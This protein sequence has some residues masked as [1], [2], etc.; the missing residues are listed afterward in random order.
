MSCRKLYH[1]S[2]ERSRAGVEELLAGAPR[3]RRPRVGAPREDRAHDV[4]V[5]RRLSFRRE[6][7]AQLG[8]EVLDLGVRR[9]RDG[10]TT[11]GRAGDSGGIGPARTS[12]RSSARRRPAAAVRRLGPNS[13]ATFSRSASF[14]GDAA[15]LACGR[16]RFRFRR[17]RRRVG[18]ELG[19]PAR[20]PPQ[21]R[22]SG[23]LRRGSPC[24][25]T[26]RRRVVGR[27]AR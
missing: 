23:P 14:G 6:R 11:G 12:T 13:V 8:D 20:A 15:L 26:R 24:A 5:G 2:K 7:R 21:A 25:A 19:A 4:V 10:P 1:R 17:G 3:R 9:P 22:T 27:R 18:L 16:G